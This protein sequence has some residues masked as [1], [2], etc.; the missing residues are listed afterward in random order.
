M[1]CSRRSASFSLSPL[2][3]VEVFP[4]GFPD[5]LAERGVFEV[6]EGSADSPPR[7]GPYLVCKDDRIEWLASFAPRQRHF[8]RIQPTLG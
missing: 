7:N 3:E 2:I 1:H 6:A 5:R 4:D 8:S